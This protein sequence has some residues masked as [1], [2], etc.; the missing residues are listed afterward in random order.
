[1]R[2]GRLDW[3]TP[4]EL[5]PEQRRVYDLIVGTRARD[6][7]T[8][9]VVD[10]EGR[11]Y[12]PFTAMLARPR[13]AEIMQTLGAAMRYEIDLSA[14]AREIATLAVA[15][16]GRSD[17]EWYSH[18]LLARRAGLTDAELDALAE[19]RLA[20]SFSDGETLVWRVVTALIG[21]GGDLDDELFAR[22]RASIGDIGLVDL[23]ALVGH[24]EFLSRS[25]R[26]WRTPARDGHQSRFSGGQLPGG[27]RTGERDQ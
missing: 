11:L 26:V 14:R 17:F 8:L 7:R 25:L 15:A 2:Y 4:G 21:P 6:A 27:Q 12:G 20:S 19:G 16:A 22:A 23:I 1:M 18:E 24:Y 9:P 13:I 10:D 3:L 5:D